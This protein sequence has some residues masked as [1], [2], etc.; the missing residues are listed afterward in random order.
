MMPDGPSSLVLFAVGSLRLAD[1]PALQATIARGGP[2]IPV[3]A[4]T[5]IED[6]QWRRAAPVVGGCTSRSQH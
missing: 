2:V 4:W 1:N 5:P 3:F 6:G